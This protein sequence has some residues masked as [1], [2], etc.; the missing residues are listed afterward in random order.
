MADLSS[1]SS[2]SL[3]SSLLSKLQQVAPLPLCDAQEWLVKEVARKEEEEEGTGG[4]V[5]AHSMS[6][7]VKE[8]VM[9]LRW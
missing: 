9:R 5:G 7:R 1:P 3:S 2:S 4:V 6:R 8:V